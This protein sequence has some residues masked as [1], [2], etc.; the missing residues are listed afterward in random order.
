MRRITD[1]WRPSIGLSWEKVGGVS[2]CQKLCWRLAGGSF[3]G[4][5]PTQRSGL[6]AL[7]CQAIFSDPFHCLNISIHIGYTS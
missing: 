3:Y 2:F 5:C 1:R 4:P 7:L 6:V